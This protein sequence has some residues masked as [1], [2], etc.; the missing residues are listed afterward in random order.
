MEE[1]VFV[2]TTQ[3][4]SG[5]KTFSGASTFSGTAN[6]TGMGTRVFTS[7]NIP[8]NSSYVIPAGLWILLY[9]MSSFSDVSANGRY[10]VQVSTDA[11]V[12]LDIRS[13]SSDGTKYFQTLAISNGTNLRLTTTIPSTGSA[14]MDWQL[15]NIHS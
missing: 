2:A 8:A 15:I 14:I 1:T 3:T 5:D 6:I 10:Q 4:I 9:R 11:W 13:R 7:G 12:D